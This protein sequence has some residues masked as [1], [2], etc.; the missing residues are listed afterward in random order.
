MQWSQE[1]NPGLAKWLCKQHRRQALVQVTLPNLWV[2]FIFDCVL[3]K[4][5]YCTGQG[6][7]AVICA[8]SQQT[9][10]SWAGKLLTGWHSPGLC[11]NGQKPDKAI[12][13]WFPHCLGSYQTCSWPVYG[14]EQAE[15]LIEAQCCSLTDLNILARLMPS[16][17]P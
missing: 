7:I 4:G 8:S 9:S 12:I 15:F 11:K 16:T 17:Q 2:S 6:Q 14:I 1:G 13:N 3:T 5:C 10:V